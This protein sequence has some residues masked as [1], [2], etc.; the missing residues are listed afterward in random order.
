MF[1]QKLKIPH[2]G[3]MSVINADVTIVFP[4]RL[5]NLRRIAPIPTLSNQVVVKELKR[6]TETTFP[7]WMS[8]QLFGSFWRPFPTS[9]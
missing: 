4:T 7:L 8:P 1:A 6:R 2:R 9:T 3:S 5:E